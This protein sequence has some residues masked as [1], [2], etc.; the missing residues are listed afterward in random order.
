MA[1]HYY[2]ALRS[3]GTP[4]SNEQSNMLLYKLEIPF[5]SKLPQEQHA[6]ITEEMRKAKRAL[7]ANIP[8][9]FDSDRNEKQPN[10]IMVTSLTRN[11]GKT[12]FSWMLARSLATE[13]DRQI[14]LVDAAPK[15]GNNET[16]CNTSPF[17]QHPAQGLMEYLY[18]TNK[19]PLSDF[20]YQTETPNLRYIAAGSQKAYM[21]TELFTSQRMSVLLDEFRHRYSDRLVVIDSFPLLGF[22]ESQALAQLV[23][24]I[25]VVVDEGSALKVDL[26]EAVKLLPSNIPVYF[27]INKCV[28]TQQRWQWLKNSI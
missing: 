6:V 1:F 25:V 10:L 20:V 17:V 4:V 8:S 5:L 26:V 3:K 14:L 21:A 18:N 13:M 23:D 11:N 12:F 24:H 7:L 2:S 16:T 9:T 19:Q 22:N 27:V 15:L 28:N